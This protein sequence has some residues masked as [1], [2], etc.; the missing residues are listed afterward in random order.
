MA[1]A[2]RSPELPGRYTEPEWDDWD[3][4]SGRGI[5][6]IASVAGQWGVTPRQ[7]RRG[8]QVWAEFTAVKS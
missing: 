5:F 4:E 8:E 3:T 7:G 2:D 1:V 6:L